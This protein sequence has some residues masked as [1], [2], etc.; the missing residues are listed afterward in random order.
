MQNKL[1]KLSSSILTKHIAY[2]F[3]MDHVEEGKK[4]AAIAAVDKHIAVCDYRFTLINLECLLY[5]S[6]R[7]VHV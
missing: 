4:A 3:P 2:Y 5:I 1:V 7:I 6:R